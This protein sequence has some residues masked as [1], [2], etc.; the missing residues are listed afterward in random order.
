MPQTA[1]VIVGK[2]DSAVAKPANSS[3]MQLKY[4]KSGIVVLGLK[5]S[6]MLDWSMNVIIIAYS[7]SAVFSIE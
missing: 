1:C 2:N 3:A 7:L 6:P 5:G 4:E